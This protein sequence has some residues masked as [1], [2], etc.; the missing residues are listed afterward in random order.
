MNLQQFLDHWKIVENPFRGEEA[1]QD[2]V[3]LRLEAA[4][5]AGL[6]ASPPTDAAAKP[7]N[8]APAT[9]AGQSLGPGVT[10]HSDFEKI[11]GDFTQPSTAIVFGEKGSGKTAIRLQLADRVHAYNAHHPTERCLWIGYDDLNPVLA[12][13]LERAKVDKKPDLTATLGK[14]R[15]V[16]H[17][18]AIL[19]LAVPAIVD[20]L[21]KQHAAR[22]TSGG[23]PPVTVTLPASDE[24]RK[25]IRKMDPS[26]RR[27]LLAL[28]V[29]YDRPDVSAGAEKR[30]QKLR[31]ALRI[32][33]PWGAMV[34]TLLV[35][36]G[37]MPAAAWIYLA[38]QQK[39]LSFDMAVLTHAD[40]VWWTIAGLLGLYL[41]VLLKRS[42]WDR[43]KYITLGHRLR[44]QIRV[45]IRSDSS[46][47]RS[48]RMIPRTLVDAAVL[49]M[50]SSDE[51][52]Y[53]ML[54]RL[55][56]VLAV[57]GYRSILVVIDRVD[58]PTLIAGDPDRM[59][60]VV[61]PMLHNKFLQFPGMGIKMLLPIELRHLLFRESAAFFQEARLDKQNLIERLN[62]S[63]AMLHDL[64][65]ARLQACR[66]PGMTSLPLLDLFA[67][68][69][70]KQDL[71]EALDQMHQPRD[72]FKL[73]YQCLV[74]H[75]ASVTSDQS[76]WRIP[77][78][79]LETVKKA[80]VERV[81]QLYRGIRPA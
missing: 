1:R 15:L 51:V 61:W 78:V 6:E 13:F 69:V 28:Q 81:T 57:L 17:I 36:V 63:G 5:Q 77:R 59:K 3:F 46:Y 30:T 67:E 70:T 8:G 73:L 22:S 38:W 43:L 71:V 47:G 53:A 35:L 79:L 26:V 24:P 80:Q 23:L 48:M 12:R 74:D 33:P 2:P 18:D 21:L 45:S 32:M 66:A 29:A 54:E 44:K 76:Q 39:R 55:K 75:C 72:A 58:E 7:A 20:V 68:D 52:R 10:S 49:P 19:T 65:N 41:L 62:W 37:W 34:W 56:R 64:C 42:V 25:A 40:S 14:L 9:G 50:T 31:N 11:A 16:D 27:D 60:A 4:S